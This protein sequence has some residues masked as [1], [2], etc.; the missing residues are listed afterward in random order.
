[1]GLLAR[2]RHE[3][4][5]AQARIAI[6]ACEGAPGDN[7]AAWWQVYCTG[8][9]VSHA[10]DRTKAVIARAANTHQN[11]GPATVPTEAP[12]AI[13]MTAVLS[14]KKTLKRNV[15][16]VRA[17]YGDL[18]REALCLAIDSSFGEYAHGDEFWIY[19]ADDTT[20]VVRRF[21]SRTGIDDARRLGRI[22]EILGGPGHGAEDSGR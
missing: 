6:Y 14:M 15:D 7:R 5:N 22:D 21:N 17:Q 11:K 2:L 18:I 4:N 1:M 8:R 16:E 19:V 3:W 13:A 20:T 12:W 9:D 10:A